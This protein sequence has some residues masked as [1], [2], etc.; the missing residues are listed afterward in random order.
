MSVK[1]YCECCDKHQPVRIDRM[2]KDHLNGENIWGDLCC[3]Q[4]HLVIATLTVEEEGVYEFKKVPP[5]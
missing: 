2:T 4:C 5:L 3:S 1:I